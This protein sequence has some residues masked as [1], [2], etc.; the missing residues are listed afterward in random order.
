[1]YV[2]LYAIK[3][4]CNIYVYEYVNIFS[5]MYVCIMD[6]WNVMYPYGQ[7]PTPAV[8]VVQNGSESSS[9]HRAEKPGDVAFSK[10]S[11]LYNALILY[12]LFITW[13]GCIRSN[14]EHAFSYV[15]ENIQS[16]IVIILKIT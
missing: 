6:G 11:S 12:D 16:D 1:M 14:G 8:F 9:D 2:C 15:L 13:H 5:Y 7:P 4:A 3:F 10:M